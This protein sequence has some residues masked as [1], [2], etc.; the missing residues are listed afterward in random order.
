MSRPTN[1]TA[2]PGGSASPPSPPGPPPGPAYFASASGSGRLRTLDLY[3]ARS[4]KVH[5]VTSWASA[6]LRSA[7]FPRAQPSPKSVLRPSI[8]LRFIER[9]KKTVRW[10]FDVKEN[11]PRPKKVDEEEPEDSG[12]DLEALVAE[13]K[14]LMAAESLTMQEAI[15]QVLARALDPSDDEEGEDEDEDEGKDKEEEGPSDW[16]F[17][18]FSS[19][20]DAEGGDAALSPEEQSSNGLVLPD[21]FSPL[22]NNGLALPS[23][24]PYNRG[25]MARTPS[26]TGESRSSSPFLSSPLDARVSPARAFPWDAGLTTGEDRMSVAESPDL[27]SSPF[28]STPRDASPS[29][30]RLTF[31]QAPGNS[32]EE[33]P[34]A[35]A[36]SVSSSASSTR[37]KLREAYDRPFPARQLFGSASRTQ[38]SYSPLSSPPSP[39]SPSS[40]S[41]WGLEPTEVLVSSPCPAPAPVRRRKKQPPVPHTS[42]RGDPFPVFSLL[43]TVFWAVVSFARMAWAL[44]ISVSV[45]MASPFSYFC[46]AFFILLARLA[47]PTLLA[48][49]FAALRHGVCSTL[50]IPLSLLRF[51]RSFG[52][53]P[54][55]GKDRWELWEVCYLIVGAL[56]MP[57]CQLL[58]LIVLFL[59]PYV[60]MG[61]YA[62]MSWYS[63]TTRSISRRASHA[64]S[65]CGWGIRTAIATVCWE[66]F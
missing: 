14:A 62:G 58:R 33:S 42:I 21:P 47:L 32:L 66:L 20:S 1:H 24:V 55:P 46:S 15:N 28:L 43:G 60:E 59:W 27:P 23:L 4:G 26:P 65:L 35:S 51:V 64:L 34:V 8:S 57:W 31:S 11:A 5:R 44:A 12:L 63:D 50:A 10:A 37:T 3:R 38:G 25:D 52:P 18:S 2:T 61:Y 41:P 17:N 39:R 53:P 48:L 13:A 40:R 36:S 45:D 54:L 9:P 29:P 7:S 19:E 30:S 49:L 6:P 22:G 16:G 56:V